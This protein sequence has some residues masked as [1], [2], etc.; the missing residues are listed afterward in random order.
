MTL[1][2]LSVIPRRFFRG[3]SPDHRHHKPYVA[4]WRNTSTMPAP[5]FTTT[6]THALE[7]TANQPKLHLAGI[8]WPLTHR[9]RDSCCLEPEGVP[10][11]QAV[12][13]L[14]RVPGHHVLAT[15][16]QVW[17]RRSSL[18]GR[19]H[20]EHRHSTV[21]DCISLTERKAKGD[22]CRYLLIQNVSATRS[23]ERHWEV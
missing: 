19:L 12:S 13:E 18:G 6:T 2:G 22:F 11:R 4:G 17:L 5:R 10:S 9:L 3:E 8:A 1:A 16:C 21:I 15:V 14:S 20:G 23:S 7:D